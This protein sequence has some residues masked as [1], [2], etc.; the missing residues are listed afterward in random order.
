MQELSALEQSW[1]G[2][3]L[4]LREPEG[5]YG[6][7]VY[8]AKRQVPILFSEDFDDVIEE[9]QY[10]SSLAASEYIPTREY[11]YVPYKAAKI[12]RDFGAEFDYSVKSWYVPDD[13]HNLVGTGLDNWRNQDRLTYLKSML[14]AEQKR[15]KETVLADRLYLDVPYK[16]KEYVKFRG[17]VYDTK[18]K[19]W[20]IDAQSPQIRFAK[21]IPHDVEVDFTPE[22]MMIPDENLI[23]PMWL[24]IPVEDQMAAQLKGAIQYQDNGLWFAPVG[25]NPDDFDDWDIPRRF[26]PKSAFLNFLVSQGYDEEKND[27]RPI[28]D[29]TKR[30][31]F[32]LGDEDS[33]SGQYCFFMKDNEI[34]GGWASNAKNQSYQR[35]S[36]PYSG[37]DFTHLR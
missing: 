33:P 4:L 6:V 24:F 25:T 8:S 30:T 14:E 23:L 37:L 1:E 26:G 21:W 29:G 5:W 2:R 36:Y 11:I 7:A 15:L 18:R 34:P 9:L 3:C 16:D 13:M 17:A 12:A 19:A 20:Y 22:P 32:V 27:C 35:W 31:F 28:P 10:R